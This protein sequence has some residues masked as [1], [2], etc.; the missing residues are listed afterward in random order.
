M[1]ENSSRLTE[2]IAKGQQDVNAT[3]VFLLEG[4]GNSPFKVRTCV[5]SNSYG[6]QCHAKAQ[7]FNQDTLSWNTIAEIPYSKMSTPKS[8]AYKQ[9]GE[10]R[11]HFEK[12]IKELLHQAQIILF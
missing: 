1:I 7:V 9:D 5:R 2:T 10:E 8:L 4:P 11:H 12:D 6:F 3:S